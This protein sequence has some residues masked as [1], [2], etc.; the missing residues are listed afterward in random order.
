[1]MEWE[2]V[3]N[4]AIVLRVCCGEDLMAAKGY[5]PVCGAGAYRASVASA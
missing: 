3:H 4:G 1:M 2:I 5:V